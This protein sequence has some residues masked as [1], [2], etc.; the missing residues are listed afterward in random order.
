MWIAVAQVG[1]MSGYRFANI[2]SYAS[3]L[4]LDGNCLGG[5]ILPYIRKDILINPN[6]AEK[7][8]GLPVE[9]NVRNRK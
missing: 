5:S 2:N 4:R 9:L 8:E 1:P 6:S 7:I 3:L